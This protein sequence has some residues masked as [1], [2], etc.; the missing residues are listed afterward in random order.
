MWSAVAADR[1]AGI[2]I[3]YLVPGH[4]CYPDVKGLR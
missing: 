1:L 3:I 4:G 2:G